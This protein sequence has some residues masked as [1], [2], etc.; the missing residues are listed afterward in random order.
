MP[1][2]VNSIGSYTFIDL[3]GIIDPRSEQLELLNR[4]GYDGT[5]ARKTGS[6]G[7]P[8]MVQTVTYC[9]D[10]SVAKDAV[11]LYKSLIGEDPQTVIRYTVNHGDFLVL[12][13]REVSCRVM[14]NSTS[15]FNVRLVCA[16]ELLG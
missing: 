8:F 1:V 6:R 5:I 4:P 12:R 14:V 10:F 7:E 16:W 3:Q 13:V 15:G 11:L 2:H 9:T